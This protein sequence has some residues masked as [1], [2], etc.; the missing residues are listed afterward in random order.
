M[1]LQINMKIRL[2]KVLQL[3]VK[4]MK[5]LVEMTKSLSKVMGYKDKNGK[6]D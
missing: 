6:M 2:R 5:V 3:L 1:V 4:M